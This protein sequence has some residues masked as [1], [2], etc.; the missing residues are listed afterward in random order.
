[1]LLLTLLAGSALT[2]EAPQEQTQ[3]VS[4]QATL[5]SQANVV[6]I[7]AL[8]KDQQGGVVYGLQSKDFVVED[9]GIEQTARLDEAP[10]GQPV[11]LVV[12]IQR[13]RRANYE[14]PRMQ[15]LKSMLGPLF[16]SGTARVALVEFD[17]QVEKTR[18]FTKDL[19]LFADDLS[20]LQVGDGGAAILDAVTYSINMLK[21]EPGNGYGC[22]C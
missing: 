3:E 16:S 18:N 2:Q 17:S 15:G 9:D 10:E 19:S 7:P 13:G 1:M 22:C 5:R 11:S 21:E 12:A 8:V 4:P 20:N 6:L 14:F